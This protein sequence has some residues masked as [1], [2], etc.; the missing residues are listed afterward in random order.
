MV[1]FVL[2]SL[3]EAVGNHV[4]D[5]VFHEK[6]TGTRDSDLLARC[7]AEK[8]IFITLDEDFLNLTLSIKHPYYGIILLPPST[9]GKQAVKE[10]FLRL[11][12]SYS[13]DDVA[14]K[15]IIVEPAIIK[16]REP[17]KKTAR[18]LPHDK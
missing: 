2:K 12:N 10:L 3:I 13:L 16:I 7:L 11:L 9:Q 18:K 15:F 5:S 8:R 1:P 17:S 14:E 4:V 6:L